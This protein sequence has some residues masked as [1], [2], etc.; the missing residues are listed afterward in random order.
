MSDSPVVVLVA[1]KQELSPLERHLRGPGI[2][3]I[4]TG[5]GPRRAKAAA[6][7]H[8]PGARLAITAGCCGGLVR[9]L[10]AGTIVVPNRLVEESEGQVRECPTPDPHWA[11]LAR[12]HAAQLGL[13]AVDGPLVTVRK[14]LLSRRSKAAAHART[15]AIAVDMETATAAHVADELGIPHLALR[16]VLDPLGPPVLSLLAALVRLRTV[17]E[18]LA[19]LIERLLDHEAREPASD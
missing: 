14:A 6:L 8:L 7:E 3:L 12:Q 15:R 1:M 5:V 16:V 2:H 4:R 11:S 19:P 10:A 18:P 13:E 17:C 9:S